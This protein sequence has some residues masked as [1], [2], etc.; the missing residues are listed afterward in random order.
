[1][2]LWELGRSWLRSRGL[3]NLPLWKTHMTGFLGNP[4]YVLLW[5]FGIAQSYRLFDWI[6]TRNYHVRYEV[7]VSDEHDP[8]GRVLTDPCALFPRSLRHLLLQSY[9]V[10]SVWLQM[11]GEQLRELRRSLLARHAQRF[12]RLSADRGRVEVYAISQRVTSDNLSLGKGERRLLARFHCEGGEAVLDP[13]SME[14]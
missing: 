9:L 11:D 14:S 10:G 5:L 1:M 12:A 13:S 7:F 4:F 8:E 6:D 3:N 2:I